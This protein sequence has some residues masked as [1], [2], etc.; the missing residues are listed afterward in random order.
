MQIEHHQTMIG[1]TVHCSLQ[2]GQLAI[3]MMWWYL[4]QLKLGYAVQT[5][6]YLKL[7]NTDTLY[8]FGWYHE[9]TRTSVTKMWGLI[10]TSTTSPSIPKD[11]N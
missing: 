5:T 9:M 2:L 3:K 6:K 7:F 8:L 10:P 4:N 1:V 11:E